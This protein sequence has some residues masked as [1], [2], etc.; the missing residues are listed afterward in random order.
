VK[1][2]RGDLLAGAAEGC[3]PVGRG[4]AVCEATVP[5]VAG[6]NELKAYAFNRDNVKSA[7]AELAVRGAESLRRRGTAYILAVGVNEYAN[8]SF[9]LKFARADADAFGAEVSR[10]Q[11]RVQAYAGV[12]VVPLHDAEATKRN[13]LTALARL[14]GGAEPLPAGAPAALARLKPARPE[15]TVFVYFAGHGVARRQTF[16]M[17]P[18]DVGYGENFRGSEEERFGLL[19]SHSISDRELE[20]A[21]ERLD[22]AQIVLVLDACNSG[23]ALEAEEKRRGPMNTK[24]LAQLAYEKG[25]FILTAAQSFQVAKELNRLGHGL[26]TH[27]LVVQGLR[28]GEA[29]AR[30][31]DGQIVMGEW[32]DFATDRVPRMQAE[33]Q[34]R[35]TRGLAAALA[36]A[37]RQPADDVN[38][39][40]PRVFYRRELAARPL[41][42]TRFGGQG[43]AQTNP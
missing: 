38:V 9:N 10:A 20:A 24:G 28:D 40:R 27:A 41:I 16:Y 36:A 4:A 37:Q 2:W 35:N 34:K 19:A 13:I 5:V 29:D 1:A 23:Q 3:K 17:I 25:I 43:G 11:A 6:A 33:E 26:L 32:L 12:E 42:V 7:D 21:L 15:D 18:H 30:P 14:S 31:R 39:Q 22:A 8:R